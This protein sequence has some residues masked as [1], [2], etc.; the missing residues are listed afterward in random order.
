VNRPAE[1]GASRVQ[2]EAA[3]YGEGYDA[4]YRRIGYWY[5]LREV[6]W[7]VPRFL[8]DFKYDFIARFRYRLFGKRSSCLLA[9]PGATD[10]FLS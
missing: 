4:L 8:R 3:H 2:V 10:R 1:N 5:Q 9:P 6:R 7:L